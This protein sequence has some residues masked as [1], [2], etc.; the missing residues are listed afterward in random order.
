MS[1]Q[2]RPQDE[3]DDRIGVQAKQNRAHKRD[4]QHSVHADRK[5]HFANGRG[6]YRYLGYSA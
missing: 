6:D 1:E 3:I 4:E 2:I 5:R